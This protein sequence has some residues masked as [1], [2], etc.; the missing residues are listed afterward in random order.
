MSETTAHGR[1]C[2][3]GMSPR[4]RIPRRTSG[5]GARRRG[6][7]P[8]V[9]LAGM[10]GA[11]KTTLLR[12]CVPDLMAAGMRPAVVLNDYV[13]AGVDAAR[14]AGCGAAVAPVP[15][16]C[17]CCDARDELLAA[18]LD[19]PEDPGTIM[20]IEANGTADPAELI[21]VLVADRRLARYALP[22]QVSVV[23]ASRWARRGWATDLEAH[24]VRTAAYVMLTRAERVGGERLEAVRAD[25]GRLAPDAR[26]VDGA[27]LCR[28]LA[29]GAGA[30]SRPAGATPGSND[31]WHRRGGHDPALHHLSAAEV[32]LPDRVTRGDLKRWL[33][34]L[35]DGVVRTKGVA[36]LDDDTW[37]YLERLDPPDS[38]RLTPIPAGDLVPV[39]VLIGPGVVSPPFPSPSSAPR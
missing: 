5:D 31:R 22:L 1:T 3:I 2:G 16:T 24:Q 38:V 19:A 20:L 26:E 18:L 30:A 14:L 13:N 11:G 27:E 35:P 33:A 37:V 39:A 29:G 21:E 8:L 4:P 25:I 36:R 17:V 6:T 12:R 32:A 15:G 23:D 28:V 34:S 9:L 7:I 10:L